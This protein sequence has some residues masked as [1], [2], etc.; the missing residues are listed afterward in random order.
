[1][2]VATTYYVAVAD[3]YAILTT[4]I[5]YFLNMDNVLCLRPRPHQVE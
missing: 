2:S 3:A 4:L 1:M 5:V